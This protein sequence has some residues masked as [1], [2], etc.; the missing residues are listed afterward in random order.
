MNEKLN[1]A[2]MKGETVKWSGRPE[3]GVLLEGAYKK[4]MLLTWIVS[5]AVIAVILAL[6]LPVAMHSDVYRNETIAL[7]VAFSLAPVLLSFQPI[8]DKRHLENDTLYAIT[9]YR[10][11]T[12]VREEVY[13]LPLNENTKVKIENRFNGCGNICFDDMIGQPVRKSRALAILGARGMEKEL[14]GLMFYNMK[15]PDTVCGYLN[16]KAA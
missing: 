16:Q 15:N 9:N 11:I 14:I 3:K 13:S 1:A 2:L 12:V 10:I 4:P 7:I 6:L 8:F 5:A